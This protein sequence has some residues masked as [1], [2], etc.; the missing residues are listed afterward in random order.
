MKD[1][2]STKDFTIDNRKHMFNRDISAVIIDES[3][4][5]LSENY[6]SYCPNLKTVFFPD[7]VQEI[8]DTA[9]ENS[10]IEFGKGENKKRVILAYCTEGSP[11]DIW[12]S[13]NKSKYIKVYYKNTKDGKN[14]N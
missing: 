6:L 2:T 11:T 12:L 1:Q 9:F 3:I 5:V 13:K 10:G 4:R 14:G 7:C 8:D